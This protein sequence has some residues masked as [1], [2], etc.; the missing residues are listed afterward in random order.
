LTGEARS[1]A[2]GDVPLG[3]AGEGLYLGYPDKFRE[4]NVTLYR[5]PSVNWAGMLEYPSR[6]DAGGRPSAWK[7]LTSLADTTQ[8]FRTSGQLTFDPP[9]D[10]QTAVVP[11]SDARLYYVRVR[12]TAGAADEAP[13]LSTVLGR[14]F[15]GANGARSGIIPAF[16]AAADANHDGYLLDAEYARRRDGFDARFVYESR[17]FYPYYGQ[18]RFVTNPSGTGVAAWATTYHRRLLKAQPAADGVF[19]DNSAGKPPTGGASLIESTSSYASDYAAVLG[20]INRG[21]APAWVLANTSGGGADADRVV[22]QVPA[23]VEEF[24]LRPLAHNW[25]Q[26]RDTADLVARRLSLTNPPGHL[27]L[28][29]LSAGGSPTDPRTRIAALAYYY[30]LADPDATL[31]NGEGEILVPA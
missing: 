5:A 8:G 24:A 19:M 29:T 2:V 27:I 22:R 23:T 30:L 17:L 6:V 12:A 28:D 13:I 20:A 7:P 4:L 3:G 15:V 21:I 26:F 18:M 11:G 25:T 14:D 9:A 1:A 16:D 10:W 31:R